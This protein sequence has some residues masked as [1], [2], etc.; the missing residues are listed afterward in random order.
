MIKKTT[1]LKGGVSPKRSRSFTNVNHA[2]R[3]AGKKA[4]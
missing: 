2:R 4:R 1:N 3:G